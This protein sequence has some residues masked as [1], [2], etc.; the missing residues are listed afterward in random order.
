MK[1]RFRLESIIVSVVAVIATVFCACSC[2]R[3]HPTAASAGAVQPATKPAILG[4]IVTADQEKNLISVDVP[5]GR[6]RTVRT[7]P[8]RTENSGASIWSVCGPDQS[9]RVA[10]IEIYFPTPAHALKTIRLDGSAEQTIF[11]RDGDPI[12]KEAAGRSMALSATGGKVAL[13]GQMHGVQMPAALLDEGP[14]EIWRLETK[15]QVSH[16]LVLDDGV[17]WFPD[18][19]QLA[20][21]RLLPRDK[22]PAAAKLDDEFGRLFANWDRVPAVC[23]L[24][25][26]SGQ[27]RIVCQGTS[28]VIAD[29]GRTMLVADFAEGK[30]LHWRRVDLAT[31]AAAAVSFSLN[32]TYIALAA[33]GDSLY[34]ALPGPDEPSGLTKYYSPL[35]G[36]QRLL[37][38][39]FG[40]FD[41]ATGRTIAGGF[42]PRSPVSF[43]TVLRNGTR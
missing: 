29:D 2:S 13:V 40:K 16:G 14:L 37:S 5:T 8:P 11:H 22:V 28:P 10:F 21:V 33:S 18:A 31:G 38:L 36:P 24:D 30:G 34:V 7:R 43:G 23:I 19:R 4:V 12:W 39:R 27:E 1:H 32:R 25:V 9:G 35:R 15:S 26:D 41:A 3:P 42:D 17:A 20:C 6:I